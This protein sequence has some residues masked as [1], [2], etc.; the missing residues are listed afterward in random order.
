MVAQGPRAPSQIL[1]DNGKGRGPV[2]ID[3]ICH[4]NGIR[5]L[6]TAPYSPT[7]TGKVERFHKTLWA[8][9]FTPKD[10]VFATIEDAQMAFDEWVESYNTKRPHQSLGGRPPVER[11]VLAR[12]Q[13]HEIDELEDEP[14]AHVPA[15]SRPSG[16]ARWVG[17]RGTIGITGFRYRVGPSFAGEPVEA[18]CQNGLVDPPCRGACHPCRAPAP[19]ARASARSPRILHPRA[20]S[21]GMSVTRSVDGG[22]SISF[23]GAG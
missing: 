1:S 3:R 13:G 20:A 6:L 17:Q 23:A 12:A 21:T 18:V 16:V 14:V 11:F 15:A 10:R 8:A 2:L 5:D 7:T 4:E 19:R 22:G 9:F